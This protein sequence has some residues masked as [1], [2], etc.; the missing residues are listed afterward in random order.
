MDKK[1]PYLETNSDDKTQVR[2]STEIS[3]KEKNKLRICR[4]NT[5]V[6]YENSSV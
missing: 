4:P 1:T 5:A 3:L 6:F 2:K